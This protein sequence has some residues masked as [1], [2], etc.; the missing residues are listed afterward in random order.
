MGEMID[1]QALFPGESEIDQLYLIQKVLGPLSTTQREQFQKNPRFIGLKFPEIIKYETLEKRFAKT[2]KK[3]IDFMYRLLKMEPNERMTASEALQHP[4]LN[5]NYELLQP[6]CITRTD[7]VK[8]KSKYPGS[9]ISKHKKI[10]LLSNVSVTENKKTVKFKDEHSQSPPPQTFKESQIII[11]IENSKNNKS[12]TNKDNLTVKFRASPYSFEQN[13]EPKPEIRLDKQQSKEG[14]RQP[15]H[16]N[17]AKSNRKKKSALEE[18]HLFNIN[19]EESFKISPRMKPVS[20]KKKTAK[21]IQ[22]QDVPYEN[23]QIKNLR[24]GIFN[25]VLPKPFIEN[26]A[27]EGEDLSNYQSARQLPNIYQ[28]Y[29]PDNKKAAG[30]QKDE[31]PDLCGGPQFMA[32]FQPEE[33]VYSKGSKLF[34][35]DYKQR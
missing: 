21:I 26:H 25:R 6:T 22:I 30:K 27:V 15:D 19:E 10:F 34:N 16:Y 24:S 33:Y 23:I 35:Y 31:D 20:I 13:I 32:S 11:P 9:A 7:S 18:S 14:I 12:T 17:E 29:H 28:Y 4:Y 2:D 1:G 8:N 5:D 3:A